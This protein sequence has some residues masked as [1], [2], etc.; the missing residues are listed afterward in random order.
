MLSISCATQKVQV[1]THPEWAGE[2]ASISSK[3]NDEILSSAKWER[4]NVGKG[5]I[6]STCAFDTL[7][8]VPQY[9]SILEI[10]PQYYEF[11]FVDHKGMKKTSVISDSSKEVAALNG[12]FY[13]MKLGNSVAFLQIDGV[14]L[15]TSRHDDVYPQING[16]LKIKNGKLSIVD[17]SPI[18]E[19]EKRSKIEKD[20]SFMAAQPML[21]KNGKEV[22]P[23]ANMPG[24]NVKKHN[25][26]VLFTKNGKVYFMVVDGRAK[27]KAEG[28]SI[29]ELSH[30]LKFLGAQQ[31]LNMDG[32]GSS[33]LY[34]SVP[35]KGSKIVN[36]PS[37]NR[38]FDHKGERSISNHIGVY[39]KE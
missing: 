33:T 6:L 4:F 28:M 15:D 18:I 2:I 3:T 16:A 30:L 11:K 13:D 35:Y 24:F 5:M 20:A 31:A 8:G 38:K 25:R 27:G 36:Y 22:Y 10:D 17:W 12:T 32:G 7:Y 39:S 26:S 23:L 29:A 19:S 14:I 37:D 34:L 9:L 21:I 1:S